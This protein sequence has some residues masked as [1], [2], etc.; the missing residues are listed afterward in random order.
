MPSRRLGEGGA[1]GERRGR[2]LPG[3]EEDQ[4]QGRLHRP[5]TPADALTAAAVRPIGNLRSHESVIVIADIVQLLYHEREQCQG[6]IFRPGSG[7]DM[8][9]RE[10]A[11]V[12]DRRVLVD[13][14]AVPFLRP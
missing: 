8:V 11:P 12:I 7:D 14:S 1:D 5:L 4:R 2:I 6:Q 9:Q 13:F 3:R 10:H